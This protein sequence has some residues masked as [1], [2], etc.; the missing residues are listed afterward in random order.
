MFSLALVVGVIAI[1]IMSDGVIFDKDTIF[2]VFLVG[3]LLVLK[4]W[5]THIVVFSLLAF[6]LYSGYFLDD[7]SYAYLQNPIQ[8]TLAMTELPKWIGHVLSIVAYTYLATA[9]FKDIHSE[10]DI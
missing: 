8:K 2:A 1:A 3:A 5:Y 7:W 10:L 9:T 4:S 6:F